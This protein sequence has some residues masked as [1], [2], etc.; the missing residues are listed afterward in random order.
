[1]GHLSEESLSELLDGGPAPGAAE[2]L[3]SC[4]VCQGGCERSSEN[5]RISKHRRTCGRGSRLGCRTVSRVDDGA[6][7]RS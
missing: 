1:M 4:P 2:H 3:S 6:V 5:F 7:G